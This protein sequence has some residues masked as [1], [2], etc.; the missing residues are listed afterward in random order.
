MVT[1]SDISN[2][3]R[4]ISQKRAENEEIRGMIRDMCYA[5]QNAVNGVENA[6][7]QTVGTL[8]RGDKMLTGDDNTLHGVEQVEADIRVKV[9][10]YKNMENAYKNI[11]QLNN[12]LR[13]EQGNEKIVRR[14]FIAMIDNEEKA[15]VSEET[16]VSQAEKIYLNTQYFFLSH[17]L[18]DLQLR[19]RG[20]TSAAD[21]ARKMALGQDERKCAW[22]YFMVALR[23]KDV[24]EQKYWLKVLMKKPLTGSEKEQLK[25]LTMLSLRES[26]E[27]ATMIR[28]YIG[29]DKIA[30]MDRDAI[31]MSILKSY[32]ASMSIVPPTYKYL[33]KHI[34]EK[35]RLNTALAGAMNNEQVGEYI[36]SVAQSDEDK[37]R[38]DIIA[39]M[40]E[41]VV[42]SCQ[43]P[44]SKQIHEEIA[45]NQKVIDAKGDLQA[46]EVL[47]QEE[48]IE[49]ASDIK[50]EDC[51]YEWLTDR[52][53]YNGKKEVIE[54]AYSKL[55]KCYRRAY[56]QYLS[57]YRKNY[58][59]KVTMKIGDYTTSTS[60][61]DVGQEE[62]NIVT[63]CNKRCEAEKAKIKDLKFYLLV[64]FGGVLLIAGIVCNFISAI[65]GPWNVVLCIACVVIG[66]GLAIGGIVVKYKNYQARIAAD[67]RCAK[68]IVRYTE[69]MHNVFS[70]MQLYRDMY[71]EF[72]ATALSDKF[73]DF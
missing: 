1:E 45:R 58:T 62:A 69:I 15:L 18:M 53:D 16:V 22:V 60:L 38:D 70:D 9:R 14:V 52:T 43:S 26:G 17:I 65:P 66:V 57:D 3:Q 21:R 47:A 56:K 13:Y 42:E 67:E 55:H 59:D 24:A 68:D 36:Q 71:K 61:K 12:K 46:A 50:L 2:L 41:T 34:A 72:D 51:L 37:M 4:E 10:L 19:K 49:Q 7:S 27:V 25:I 48:R 54:F 28:G 30:E 64:I 35:D 5:M 20:E 29:I 32:R 23:R 31:V 44:V 11:R 73:F 63:H 40:F 6:R 8:Q 39:R 33:E